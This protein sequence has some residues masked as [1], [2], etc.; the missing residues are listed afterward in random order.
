MY[1][2][3]NERIREVLKE[4]DI[5]LTSYG[6]N[7]EEMSLSK[8]SRQLSGENAM[9][10]DVV[11]AILRDFPD[12]SA[13]WLLFGKGNMYKTTEIKNKTDIEKEKSYTEFLKDKIKWLQEKNSLLQKL[14]DEKDKRIAYYEALLHEAHEDYIDEKQKKEVV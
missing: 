14:I 10:T 8:F 12:V 4:H 2:V 11:I 1:K 3:I 13:E 9:T 6:T 5:S 7:L